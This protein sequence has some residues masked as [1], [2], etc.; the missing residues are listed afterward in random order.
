MKEDPT[1]RGWVEDGGEQAAQTAAL[2]EE[3]VDVEHAAQEFGPGV[4]MALV[5]G[6]LAGGGGR[7]RWVAGW[8]GAGLHGAS[9]IRLLR[10]NSGR[11][12]DDAIA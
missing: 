11:W 4:A 5:G 2:A 12:R 10:I 8:L 7:N 9:G 1:D 6:W 3:D